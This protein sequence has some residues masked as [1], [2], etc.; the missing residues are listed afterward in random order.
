M[1]DH[2]RAVPAGTA[3]SEPYREAI[4][5]AERLRKA[6]ER[7]GIVL[8]SLRGDFPVMGTPQLLLGSC[9]GPHAA[10]LAAVLEQVPAA[11]TS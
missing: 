3:D 7:H 2:I 11:A 4:V 1:S 6:L 8:P 10:D 9:S 5:L